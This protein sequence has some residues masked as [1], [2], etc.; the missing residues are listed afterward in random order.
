MTM[1]QKIQTLR[2]PALGLATLALILVPGCGETAGPVID[3]SNDARVEDVVDNRVEWDGETIELSGEVEEIISPNAFVMG[4]INDVDLGSEE[5]V[6][7]VDVAAT[8]GLELEQNVRVI[9]EVQSFVTEEVE[10][11]YDIKWNGDIRKTL[12][13]EY[14][15]K[16]AVIA[17][18][19]MAIE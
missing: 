17:K 13:V 16:P 15:G 11:N 10:R 5:K 8:Q 1:R 18:S 14:D 2:L 6:L 3:G 7:I 19:T 12:E 4:E 9:G